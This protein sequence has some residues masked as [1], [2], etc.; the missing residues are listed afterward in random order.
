MTDAFCALG[1]LHSSPHPP[2][3]EGEVSGQVQLVEA[4]ATAARTGLGAALLGTTL[5]GTGRDRGSTR[6]AQGRG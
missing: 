6:A 3:Q 2:G 4:L 1:R 5:A